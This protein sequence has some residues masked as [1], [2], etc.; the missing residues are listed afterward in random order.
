[1]KD[2]STAETGE[3][4]GGKNDRSSP[5]SFNQYSTYVYFMQMSREVRDTFLL[6]LL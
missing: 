6:Y 4:F 2:F 1:M 5:K 3:Q